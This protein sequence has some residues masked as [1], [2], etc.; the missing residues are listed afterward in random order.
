MKFFKQFPL[1]LLTFCLV[2]ASASAYRTRMYVPAVLENENRGSLTLIELNVTGGNGNV[3]IN[4]PSTVDPDTIIS[5]RTAAAYA[6]SFLGLN[7]SHYN[8]NYSIED[9][10]ASV[11]GPS[12]GL[13]FTLLAVAAL[14]HRQL[15]QNFTATGTI[16]G[17]GRIGQIGGIYDKTGAAKSVNMRYVL[18]PAAQ[19]SSFESFLYYISQQ[20]YGTPMVEVAN[21]SQAVKYAFGSVLPQ[22]LSPNLAQN[23]TIISL[24]DSNVTCTDCN[25]SIFALL[26]NYTFNF[27]DSY[28]KNMSNNFSSAR[29]Q[30]LNNLNDYRQIVNK[31]YLYTGADFSFLDFLSAFTLSNK[32]NFDTGSAALVLKNISDYCSSLMPPPM[33]DKNYEYVIGGEVR[34]L[35]G[36]ITITNAENMLSTEQT[37]DDIIESLY[38]SASAIGWCKAADEQFSIASS[39]GGNYV[40]VSPSLKS[41]VAIAINTANNYG[42]SGLYIQSATQAY[43]SG[44]YATALYAAT[45]AEVFMPPITNNATISQLYNTSISNIKNVTL[46]IWPSQFAS[47][48]EFYLRESMLS[49]GAE[50]K[51]SVDQAYTTS[52]LAV[53]LESTNKLISGSFVASNI[54][55]S[56]FSQQAMQEISSIESKVAEMY[57]LLI[58]NALLLF[59]ILVVLIFHLMAHKKTAR[60]S[61]TRRRK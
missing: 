23:Y 8:F 21:V 52:M 44:D 58:A 50:K 38:T 32:N 3:Y 47:Q 6:A 9:K 11:S 37:T 26:V 41:R 25:T 36:N 31:G 54:T 19:D 2:I 17:D 56:G 14:Q 33:T 12:G 51:N 13:A 27:T 61:R 35:W 20:T 59:A 49:G 4:G 10:N 45:Y 5:A 57:L 34:R 15:A 22:P 42:N 18:V 28:I 30:L 48:S 46:G 7:S 1:F 43:N 55:Q 53:R 24:G 40:Q 16:S 29:Q 60:R 39:M